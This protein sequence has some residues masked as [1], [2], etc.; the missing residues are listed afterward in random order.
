MDGAQWLAAMGDRRIPT[1]GESMDKETRA[2][3]VTYLYDYGMPTGEIAV[4][5]DCEIV[6]KLLEY[7]DSES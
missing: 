7:L 2:R 1:S 3:V 4:M 6:K 5:T